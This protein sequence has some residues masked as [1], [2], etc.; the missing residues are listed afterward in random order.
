MRQHNPELQRSEVDAD[1]IIEHQ[2]EAGAAED[3]G[4]LGDEP[5]E[6]PAD[7]QAPAKRRQLLHAQQLLPVAAAEADPRAGVG[8]VTRGPEHRSGQRGPSR[9]REK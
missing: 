4:R 5:E 3:T 9:I 1:L 8:G 6:D 7:D 2:E